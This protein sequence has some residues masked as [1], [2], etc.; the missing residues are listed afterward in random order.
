MIYE[1][2]AGSRVTVAPGKGT[3]ILLDWFEEEVCIEADPRFEPDAQEPC[4][5]ATCGEECCVDQ[6]GDPYV[7]VIPVK[8]LVIE[9][10][11][12]LDES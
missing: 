3:E 5:V 10:L 9:G 8:P 4:I 11:G 6:R 1:S 7:W 12:A 2:A